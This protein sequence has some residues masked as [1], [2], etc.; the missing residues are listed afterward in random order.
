MVTSNSWSFQ[1][2]EATNAGL[3]IVF[4]D[5]VNNEKRE[6]TCMVE[7]MVEFPIRMNSDFNKWWR[8]RDNNPF[9]IIKQ[10]FTCVHI[11]VNSETYTKKEYEIG[12]FVGRGSPSSQ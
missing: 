8:R 6:D 9:R 10:N 12:K 1:S 11:S 4:S 2:P 3:V 5:F 7:I